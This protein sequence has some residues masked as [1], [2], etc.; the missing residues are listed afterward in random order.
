V[1]SILC[2]FASRILEKE[3]DFGPCMTLGVVLGAEILG[4]VVFHDYIKERRT[5]EMSIAA[6][7]PRWLTRKV[8]T[9]IAL[10]GFV[11]NDCQMMFARCDAADKTTDRILSKL[12]FQKV[13]LPNMRGSGRDESLFHMTREAWKHSR[14]ER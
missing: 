6:I 5:I 11:L 10:I 8:I 3:I 14:F 4:V 1:N 12:G 13:T 2:D 9:E 7:S